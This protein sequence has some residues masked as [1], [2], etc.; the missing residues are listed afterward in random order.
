MTSPPDGPPA[1]PIEIPFRDLSS[2]ALDG[3]ITEFVTRDGTDYGAVEKDLASKKK[4]LLRQLEA[5]E[6]RLLFDPSTGTANFHPR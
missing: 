2:E 1:E 5:G 6:I 3:L 4:S